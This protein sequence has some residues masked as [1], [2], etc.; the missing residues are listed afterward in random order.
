ME[1]GLHSDA[2][3]ARLDDL[4]HALASFEPATESDKVFYGQAVSNFDAVV[5]ARRD[6]VDDAKERL[7]SPLVALLFAGALVFILTM[8]GFSAVKEPV[9]LSLIVLLSAVVGAGLFAAVVLDY[10]FAGSLRI[11]TD[12]FL[13]GA[14][15]GLVRP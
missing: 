3:S 8:L 12:P 2:A 13:E 1:K 7:P 14:L 10:P 9:L 4:Q 6:R 5:D 15:K 11:S